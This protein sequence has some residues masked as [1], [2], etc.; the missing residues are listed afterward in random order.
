MKVTQ[1][2]E[3]GKVI[4]KARKVKTTGESYDLKPSKEFSYNFNSTV[5]SAASK[6]KP[7][8]MKSAE[9]YFKSTI[10]SSA[11]KNGGLKPAMSAAIDR[12]GT[13][14]SAADNKRFGNITSGYRKVGEGEPDSTALVDGE[15]V[16]FKFKKRY[17]GDTPAQHVR[18][19]AKKARKK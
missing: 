1:T 2:I 18:D 11:L 3:I 13:V 4:S 19:M 9:S 12:V 10:S 16:D 8:K 15:R 6:S 7:S 17:E 14:N 5:D